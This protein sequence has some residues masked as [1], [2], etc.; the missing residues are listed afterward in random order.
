MLN[1]QSSS[2]FDPPNKTKLDS[3]TIVNASLGYEFKNVDVSLFARNIFDEEYTTT[4]F[5]LTDS[6]KVGEPRTVGLQLTGHW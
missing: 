3:R 5:K 2:F 1:Y 4:I 6:V